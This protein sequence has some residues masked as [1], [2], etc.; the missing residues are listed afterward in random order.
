M[1]PVNKTVT[2]EEL[3]KWRISVVNLILLVGTISAT[4]GTTVSIIDAIRRPD[5]WPAVILYASVLPIFTFFT[6]FRKIDYRIRTWAFLC[7]AYV[8]GFTVLLSLGL[9]GSGRIYLIVLPI[10]ALILLGQRSGIVMGSIS[11]VTLA[12]FILLSRYTNILRGFLLLKA[13]TRSSFS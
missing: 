12:A 2:D 9:G 7:T 5:Q 10:I 11:L 4:V 13:A 1:S 6:I 8:I 3:A